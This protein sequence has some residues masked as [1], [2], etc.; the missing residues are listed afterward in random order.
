MNVAACS[1]LHLAHRATSTAASGNTEADTAACSQ[2]ATILIKLSNSKRRPFARPFCIYLRRKCKL[3][4]PLLR[5]CSA[6]AGGAAPAGGGG[7]VGKV[8]GGN[9]ITRPPKTQTARTPPISGSL[10][11]LGGRRSIIVKILILGGRASGQDLP[12]ERPLTSLSSCAPEAGA[13]S[14]RRVG[15]ERSDWA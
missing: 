4:G 2:R 15:A 14:R 10:R 13:S 11:H 5:S 3:A 8:G 7:G 12:L 6:E 9:A 1:P